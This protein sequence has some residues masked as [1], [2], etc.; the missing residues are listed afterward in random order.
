MREQRCEEQP[1]TMTPD[2]A[3]SNSSRRR[4]SSLCPLGEIRQRIQEL[5][6]NLPASLESRRQ[7]MGENSH[8]A[9]SESRRQSMGKDFH[10]SLDN[11]EFLNFINTKWEDSDTED[12]TSSSEKA[13]FMQIES[14]CMKLNGKRRNSYRVSFSLSNEFPEKN[15]N[16]SAGSFFR[17]FGSFT[18]Q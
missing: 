16:F 7:S 9:M 4:S 10:A 17:E 2:P 3:V 14:L 1:Q 8:P 15:L 11:D 5:S 6:N 18:N 12:S 13:E